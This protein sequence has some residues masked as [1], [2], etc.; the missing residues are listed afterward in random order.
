MVITLND[1]DREII[2]D[3]LNLL[4]IIAEE[5]NKDAE[6]GGYGNWV[7]EVEV[8]YKDIDNLLDRFSFSL[9]EVGSQ[10]SETEKRINLVARERLAKK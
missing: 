5:A 1:R 6:W 4:F 3:G 8:Y 7:E 10:V 9:L 2:Q